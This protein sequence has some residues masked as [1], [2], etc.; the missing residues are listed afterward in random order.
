MKMQLNRLSS[1]STGISPL[2]ER[3][4]T[5]ALQ[6]RSGRVQRFK[7]PILALLQA[8]GYLLCKGSEP[9]IQQRRDRA[10]K[11]Y[12]KVYDPI[13]HQS[14]IFDSEHEVRIWLEERYYHW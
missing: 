2:I 14:A 12:F 1:K 11:C 6:Q 9:Q 10:G 4:E 8:L 3:S 7:I 5:R 13:S